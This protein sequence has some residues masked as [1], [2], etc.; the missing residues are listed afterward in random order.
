MLKQQA[1]AM[2]Q[3]F[4]E[5]TACDVTAFSSEA[6]RVTTR[7][8]PAPWPF[9]GIVVGF[10]AGVVFCVEQSYREW[11]DGAASRVERTELGYLLGYQLADE[12]RRRGSSL[13]A[14]PP[15]MGWALARAPE[16][17]PAPAGYSLERVDR[18]W[19]EAWQARSL[20]PNALGTPD[21]AHRTYRNQFAAA[22]L[23]TAAQ[24]VAV[25]GA[26]DTAGLTEI[27]VD[28]LGPERGRGFGSL[29]VSALT[30]AILDGG[31]I[32]FYEC[33]VTNVRSQRTALASGFLPI[34]ASATIYEAGLGI[35]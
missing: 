13:H 34:C 2:Q 35:S 20:F 7:P 6:V 11:A 22:V 5:V 17:S 23:D 9:T 21:Q 33:A 18:A 3:R 12:A 25:A 31:G 10:G 8:E 27:G 30:R 29:T 26:Y 19:M 32:P 4:A 24:P 16:S 28:V 14:N 15:I 1:A